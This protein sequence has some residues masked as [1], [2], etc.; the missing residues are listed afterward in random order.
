[1]KK[2]FKWFL[3]V[4]LLISLFVALV[5]GRRDLAQKYFGYVEN[6]ENNLKFYEKELKKLSN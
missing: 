1:M 3:K 6:L 2:S 5:S 4:L